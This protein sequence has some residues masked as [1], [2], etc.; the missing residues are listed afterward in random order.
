MRKIITM[1]KKIKPILILALFAVTSTAY[2]QYE[3]LEK[4]EPQPGKP[5]IAFEKYKLLS[6]DLTLIIHEDHS[7]PIVHV[8]VAYHV[9]SA[10]ESVRNSGFAHFF[11]HMMFQ[12]SKNIADEE[13]FKLISKAGGTNNA[14]TA[15]DETVYINTAPS[16]FTE[17]M[18]WMEADRMSTLLDG[19]TQAKFES[20]RNAVKNEKKQSYD[21]QP[22]G[23]YVERSN[24]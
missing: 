5:V 17:T 24:V 9:G 18:L 13:H 16:N 7:D 3:L 1:I 8:E 6:N 21:N 19:F 12:G 20:Q 2:G 23:C 11:E 22:Y 10:R 4:V 15:F 14:F